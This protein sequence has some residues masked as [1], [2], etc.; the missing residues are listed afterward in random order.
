MPA[1][2][3]GVQRALRYETLQASRANLSNVIDTAQE[4]LMVSLQRGGQVARSVPGLL[5]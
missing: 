5:Q 4:G 2:K 1:V 3:S